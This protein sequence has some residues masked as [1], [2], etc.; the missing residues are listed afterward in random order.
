MCGLGLQAIAF[1]MMRVSL[2]DLPALPAILPALQAML[3]LEE[4]EE[5]GG[6]EEGPQAA[7]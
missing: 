6:D 2:T 1:D 5:E 7:G 3:V 4:G